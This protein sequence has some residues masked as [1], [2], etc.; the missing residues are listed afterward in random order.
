MAQFLGD[1]YAERQPKVDSEC[2]KRSMAETWV[3]AV[4]YIAISTVVLAIVLSA[5]M[6]V[7]AKLRDKNTIAQTKTVM[8]EL[9]NTIRAVARD[10]GAQ[11]VRMLDIRAGKLVIDSANERI[12]WT[13][14]TKYIESEPG[15]LIEEGTLKIMTSEDP[16][17]IGKYWINLGLDYSG[18]TIDLDSTS[19]L[20]AGRTSLVFEN[21]GVEDEKI[22]IA[23]KEKS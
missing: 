4:L 23:V 3:S 8:H 16:V 22:K 10:V 5:G 20:I 13:K 12:N 19:V 7:V 18:S 14:E 1:F 17:V 11:R 9:D 6:P 2:I 21:L 15:S